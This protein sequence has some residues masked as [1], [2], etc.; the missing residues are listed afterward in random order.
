MSPVERI[1]D[2]KSPPTVAKGSAG[3]CENATRRFTHRHRPVKV[4]SKEKSLYERSTLV[5]DNTLGLIQNSPAQFQGKGAGVTCD[6][7]NATAERPPPNHESEQL[8]LEG[9]YLNRPSDIPKNARVRIRP[10]KFCSV[11]PNEGQFRGIDSI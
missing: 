6:K 10:A 7:M 1:P 9:T 4:R 5:A 8:K 3:L 2:A 11:G